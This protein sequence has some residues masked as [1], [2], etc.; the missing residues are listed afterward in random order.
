MQIDPTRRGFLPVVPVADALPPRPSVEAAQ[1]EPKVEPVAQTEKA[2]LA[3]DRRSLQFGVDP[4]SG[5][6]RIQ[7]VD[8]E[9]GDV[10]YS[11]PEVARLRKAREQNQ[12]PD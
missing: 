12:Q 4:D 3:G 9:T 5:I 2:D 7:V 10:L 6:M 1:Q 8:E 11:A